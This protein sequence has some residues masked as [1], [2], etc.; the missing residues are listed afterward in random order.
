[1]SAGEQEQEQEQGQ[2]EEQ[3]QQEQE[4]PSC[5]TPLPVQALVPV[6]LNRCPGDSAI[7]PTQLGAL[8]GSSEGGVRD[9][10]EDSIFYSS[11]EIN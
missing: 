4:P 11:V 10:S 8:R 3:Q 7:Y 6:K 1:M 9:S 5:V 2:E